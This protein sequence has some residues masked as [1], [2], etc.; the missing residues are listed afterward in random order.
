MQALFILKMRIKE[1][2]FRQKSIRCRILAIHCGQ[3]VHFITHLVKYLIFL[4]LGEIMGY[5]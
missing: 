2:L 3:N 5:K 4:G 1:P